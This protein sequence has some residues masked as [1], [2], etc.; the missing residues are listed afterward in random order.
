V[1]KVSYSLK[2]VALDSYRRNLGQ[3]SVAVGNAAAN[4]EGNAKQSIEMSSGQYKKYP[5]RK[6]HPHWSSP[7]GT[8]PNADMGGSG[9]SGS[10]ESKMTGRT[11]AEVNVGAKY[12]IPLELGWMTQSGTHVPA[13]PFLR[14]AVE[15]EAP[16]FQAA[17]KVILKGG[18]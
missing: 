2:S 18:K 11:S 8:P 3:L 13:R 10:I 15:K 16:A 5:G 9:L 14:P 7:P 12:G 17:V 4:I 1:I 6:E